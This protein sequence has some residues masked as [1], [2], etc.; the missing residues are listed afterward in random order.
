MDLIAMADP[1]DVVQ[2]THLTHTARQVFYANLAVEPQ[3]NPKA[4]AK[5]FS[6]ILADW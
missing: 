6:C 5:R 1:T 4:I 2:P 3:R